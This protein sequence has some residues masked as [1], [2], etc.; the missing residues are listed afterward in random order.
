MVAHKK[1]VLSESEMKQILE[2]SGS[3]FDDV[4]SQ[5]KNSSKSERK[6]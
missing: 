3:E 4:F 2:D 5:N 6:K 1:R